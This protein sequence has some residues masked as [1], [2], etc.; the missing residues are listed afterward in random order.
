MQ[1]MHRPEWYLLENQQSIEQFLV[2]VAL[3]LQRG[4][5][6]SFGIHRTTVASPQLFDF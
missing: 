4:C 2:H 1:Q 3:H 5:S 6:K